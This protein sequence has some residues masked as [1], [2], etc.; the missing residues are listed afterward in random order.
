MS[1][2]NIREKITSITAEQIELIGVKIAKALVNNLGLGNKAR[3]AQKTVQNSA[4]PV[5]GMRIMMMRQAVTF[6]KLGDG[7]AQF[8]SDKD[9]AKFLAV[10]LELIKKDITASLSISDLFFEEGAYIE[11]SDYEPKGVLKKTAK[12]IGVKITQLEVP[13]RYYIFLKLD[14]ELTHEKSDL[15]FSL[16]EKSEG[17][18]FSKKTFTLKEL[19]E[20]LNAS[21]KRFVEN[22]SC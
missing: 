14:L 13:M 1:I 17:V 19:E 2:A 18:E 15:V 11:L 9:T 4:K 16:T 6:A 22:D 8:L 3:I 5:D 21:I 7:K 10:S 20:E 12:Q